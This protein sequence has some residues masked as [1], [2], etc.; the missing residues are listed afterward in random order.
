MTLPRQVLQAGG[1]VPA[2]PGRVVLQGMWLLALVLAPLLVRG[3]PEPTGDP[4]LEYKV[5]AAFLLN[6][7]K[8]VGWPAQALSSGSV[9]LV[10]GT[11]SDD[12]V[13]PVLTQALA[14][15]SVNGHP[16]K[17]VTFED[18]DDLKHCHLLFLSRARKGQVD[19]VLK[20]LA[21]APVL[22]V[23]EMEDFAHRGGIINL[24][25]AG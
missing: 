25:R 11:I 5:K 6:F 21:G 14:G 22:T 16:L 19:E 8:F 13:A 23:G 3:A 7:A 12:P 10:V 24:V 1:S 20:R 2:G 17:V 18:A 15:K 4:A 9:P